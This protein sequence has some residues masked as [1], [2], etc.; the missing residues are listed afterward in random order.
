MR[1]CWHRCGCCD[2]ASLTRESVHFNQMKWHAHTH[3][4]PNAFTRTPLHVCTSNWL[5]ATLLIIHY[6]LRDVIL[7]MLRRR[8]FKRIL[9]IRMKVRLN[10][11]RKREKRTR[12]ATAERKIVFVEHLNASY[13]L[14]IICTGNL[15]PFSICWRTCWKFNR[16]KARTWEWR[17]NVP[18]SCEKLYEWRTDKTMQC[19]KAV[20]RT[21][22]FPNLLHRE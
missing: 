10:W 6:H 12:A 22:V 1:S 8:V 11:K 15:L 13:S 14:N 16:H 4:N 18:F 7:G 2:G 5:H 19:K 20:N 21:S 17:E 3:T 9:T